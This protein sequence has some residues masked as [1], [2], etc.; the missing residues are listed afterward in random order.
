MIDYG[1]YPSFF[2]TE[3]SA[4]QLINTP[5]E[6]IFTSRYS[7]WEVEIKRQYDF[8]SEAL[9]S[10]LNHRVISRDVLALG[11][12]KVTYE[13]GVHIYINY[14]G[15]GYQQDGITVEAMNF[16]VEEGV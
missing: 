1:L 13:N 5:S 2:I 7:D 15:N 12:I 10:V 11:V 4:Y 8:I 16:F 14:S 9:T 3:A 6:R